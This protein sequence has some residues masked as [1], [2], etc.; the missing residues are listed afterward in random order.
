MKTRDYG[1]IRRHSPTN[2]NGLL[3]AHPLRPVAWFYPASEHLILRSGTDLLP[4]LSR[5]ER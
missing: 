2:A 4:P 1:K 5:V 3:V